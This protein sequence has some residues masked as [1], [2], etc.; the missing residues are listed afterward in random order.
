MVIKLSRYS[1]KLPRLE[2]DWVG[3]QALRVFWQITQ[4]RGRPGWLSSSPGWVFWQIT[5]VRGRLGWLSSSPGFLTNYSS[6]LI[7]FDVLLIL[8]KLLLP[9]FV[10]LLPFCFYFFLPLFSSI[11]FFL[12]NSHFSFLFHIFWWITDNF[13]YCLLTFTNYQGFLLS[14]TF[15]LTYMVLLRLLET[16]LHHLSNLSSNIQPILFEVS[17]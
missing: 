17:N 2:G 13:R 16:I 11:F 9:F 7:W 8:E 4:V 12:L 5:Q 3:Y 10:A 6:Y 14:D 15:Q 1:D